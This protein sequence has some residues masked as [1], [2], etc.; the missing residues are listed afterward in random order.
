MTD[1]ELGTESTE[2]QTEATDS[3]SPDTPSL[4]SPG[5]A[6]APPFDPDALASKTADLLRPMIEKE[7][8]RSFQSGKDV[9]YSSVEKIHSYLEAAGGDVG[10]ATRD[11]KLDEIYERLDSE[12]AAGPASQ[13]SETN[14]A[15]MEARTGQLLRDAGIDFKDPD[16]LMLSAQYAGRITDPNQW[17]AVVEGFTGTRQTNQAKQENIPGAAAAS[18]GGTV[19]SAGGDED[20]E[21]LDAEL[22]RLIAL[23]AT[24]ETMAARSEIRKKL[25]A[26]HDAQGVLNNVS[27]DRN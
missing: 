26:Q 8:A 17:L 27:F 24:A 22:N 7:V 16:Y 6:S 13:G 23:P 4:V 15:F 25:T 10:K 2:E 20:I 14:Q 3:P 21:S 11:M 19:L 1:E 5:E 12:D 9:R 18:E